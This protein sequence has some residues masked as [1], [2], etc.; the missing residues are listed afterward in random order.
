VKN[1]KLLI[2]LVIL[3]VFAA[4]ECQ[5]VEDECNPPAAVNGSQPYDTIRLD[6]AGYVVQQAPGYCGATA[7]YTIFK[8]YGDHTGANG[9]AN[10][11]LSETIPNPGMPELNGDSKIAGWIDQNGGAY[12]AKWSTLIKSA[13]NMNNSMGTPFYRN[14]DHYD[15]ETSNRS[16][17]EQQFL[18]LLEY[19]KNDAPVF[20]HLKRDYTS[21]H[22]VILIGYDAGTETVYYMD[23]NYQDYSGNH[24]DSVS[25]CDFINEH[26]FPDNAYW[27]SKWIGF[28]HH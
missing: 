10:V 2:F 21:G 5:P 15:S 18:N 12:A 26:W 24:I 16:I 19:L 27:D 23:P 28:S 17:K 14:I 3:C 4:N 22:Y 20:I 25:Y 8:Y 6:S 13:E 7:F 11:D 1:R 9:P